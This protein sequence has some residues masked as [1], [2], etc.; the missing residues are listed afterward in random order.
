MGRYFADFLSHRAKLVVEI[1]GDTHD[2]GKDETRDHWFQSEG[3]RTLRFW[4]IDVDENPVGVA[5]RIFEE[6][7]Q[8]YA[9]PPQNGEGRGGVA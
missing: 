1:D 3:Y 5:D 6:L 4:N 9:P 8:R 7:N 2:P